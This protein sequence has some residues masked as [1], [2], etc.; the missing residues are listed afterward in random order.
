MEVADIIAPEGVIANLRAATKKQALSE[1]A[2]RAAQLT[3][4]GEQDIFVALSERE[5]LGST[6]F[7]AGIAIPHSKVKGIDRMRGIFARLERPIDFAAIDGQ[8]VDLLCLLLA[9]IAG[10]ADHLK[11]LARVSRILRDHDTCAKLRNASN[12]AAIYALLTE[13]PVGAGVCEG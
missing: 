3:G 10:S 12:A 4:V 7:G 13:H 9:P 2:K 6:G 5:A 1:L 8:P 11:A